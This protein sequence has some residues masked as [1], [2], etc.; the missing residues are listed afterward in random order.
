MEHQ[1]KY[2]R[3]R[4]N[5]VGFVFQF[6]NLMPNLTAYENV[7]LSVE[8]TQNPLKVEEVLREVGLEDRAIIFRHRCREDNN[9]GISSSSYC[10]ESGNIIM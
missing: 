3:Y 9:K 4:R 10:K 2:W 5:T 7:K 1:K 6:Y 8:I